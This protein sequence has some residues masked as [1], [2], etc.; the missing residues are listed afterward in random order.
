MR[1]RTVLT[2]TLVA[3]VSVAGAVQAAPPKGVEKTVSYTDPTPDPTGYTAGSDA[4]HCR[5]ALPMEAPIALKVP[6]AGTVEV[7]IGGFQG[8]WSLMITDSA[9]DTITGADVN[10]PEFESTSF[11][12]KKAA[13]VNIHP[14]NFAGS[15]QAQVTYK[16]TPK[17]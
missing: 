13:T 2:A 5:G 17:K 8:D 6:G 9:G 12:L 11:K 16:F 7:S 10:P 14:C 15:P 4:D 1:I 3:A